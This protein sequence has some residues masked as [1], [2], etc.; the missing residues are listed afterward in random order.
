MTAS[1]TKRHELR[2]EYEFLR[3]SDGVVLR[4]YSV[5]GSYQ[6][7][8]IGEDNGPLRDVIKVVRYR[9]GGTTVVESETVSVYSP[10]PF[11]RGVEPYCVIGRWRWDQWRTDAP[12]DRRIPLTTAR[13]STARRPRILASERI[14]ARQAEA[15]ASDILRLIDP[16]TSDKAYT[17]AIRVVAEQVRGWREV[18]LFVDGAEDPPVDEPSVVVPTELCSIC[19]GTGTFAR[20]GGASAAP[21]ACQVCGGTGRVEM[22]KVQRSP[23]VQ[24]P[25]TRAKDDEELVT[26][27]AN[28]GFDLSCGACASVFYTGFGGHAHDESC[29]SRSL[30]DAVV[31]DAYGTYGIDEQRLEADVRNQILMIR[32]LAESLGVE[33]DICVA[34]SDEDGSPKT[35]WVGLR[36]DYLARLDPSLPYGATGETLRRALVALIAQMR[37]CSTL[38]ATKGRET[39]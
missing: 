10:S 7:W 12:V 9:D 37:H 5:D 34:W 31:T 30:R 11:A 27:C 23:S 33:P 8:K 26:A 28:I 24:R 35:W 39:R 6:G 17:T 14:S 38:A 25:D 2:L 20:F 1:S 22:T 13:H 3:P 29:R 16:S 19:S 18:G 36:Q 21:E 15:V 32:S 4:V